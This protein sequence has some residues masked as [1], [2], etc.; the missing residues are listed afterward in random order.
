MGRR[1]EV[2]ICKQAL[3]HSPLKISQ[4]KNRH[5]TQQRRQSYPHCQQPK[6]RRCRQCITST[7]GIAAATENV[8]CIN[9]TIF[10]VRTLVIGG[11]LALLNSKAAIFATYKNDSSILKAID[12]SF[13]HCRL[14]PHHYLSLILYY[15]IKIGSS[16]IQQPTL[17]ASSQG[18]IIFYYFALQQTTMQHL[19]SNNTIAPLT[20]H[21][22]L[23]SL[24]QL[25]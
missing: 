9:A 16:S 7:I 1:E 21:S 10:H 23:L 24:Q 15:H 18:S 8:I 3:L 20:I 6:R 12:E 19:I 17:E 5:R 11:Q 13:L 14:H 22:M 4:A 2:L 25:T